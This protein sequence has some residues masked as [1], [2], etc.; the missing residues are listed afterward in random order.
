MQSI[1]VYECNLN[2]LVD[3]GH[4]EGFYIVFAHR[5]RFLYMWQIK[6]PKSLS[7]AF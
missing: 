3:I 5:C 2:E 1:I 4:N 7:A 6:S